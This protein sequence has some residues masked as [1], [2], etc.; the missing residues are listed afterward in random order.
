DPHPRL[1]YNIARAYDQANDFSNA[2]DYYRQYVSSESDTDPALLK[3]SN[4]SMDRLRGLIAREE[5]NKNQADSE[6]KRLEEEKHR[7]EESAK[8]EAE[9]AKKAREDFDAQQ[10]AEAEAKERSQNR[11]KTI[12]YVAGG[13]GAAGVLAG[14]T[15]TYL[16]LD[17]KG[18]FKSAT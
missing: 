3:K 16:T 6:R 5:A 17:S 10:K 8:V 4:L 12:A 9:A 2:L 11:G 1:L 15:F 13:L 7:A 18:K 14:G